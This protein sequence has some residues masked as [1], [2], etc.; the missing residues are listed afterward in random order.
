MLDRRRATLDVLRI[1]GGLT[2]NELARE[3]RITRAAAAN[4][5]ARLVADGLVTASGLKAS[6]R[7][8]SVVYELAAKADRLFH[9]EYDSFAVDLMDE[10]ARAGK[11]QIDRVLRGVGARWIAKDEP[12]VEKLSGEA[13]LERAAKLIGARG[14]MPTLKKMGPRLHTLQNHNC[15]IAR[16]CR[17]HHETAGMVKHWIEAL[18]GGRIERSKCIYEGGHAC[19]YAI[20]GQRKAR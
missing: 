4:H 17:A 15:P 20:A 7:R 6:G 11:G 9:Q 2:V 12:Q 10:I 3:L 14:F 5:I 1:R 8:P 13:R 16:V 18:F 19:E